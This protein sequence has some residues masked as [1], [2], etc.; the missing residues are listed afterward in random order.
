MVDLSKTHP[1]IIHWLCMFVRPISKPLCYCLSQNGIRL[2]QYSV[3]ILRTVCKYVPVCCW[4]PAWPAVFGKTCS[5]QAERT[6]WDA[7]SHNAMRS[8]WPSISSVTNEPEAILT[9]IFNLRL[10]SSFYQTA[11][12]F[13]S[14]H[15]MGLICKININMTGFHSLLRSYNSYVL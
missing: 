4:I 15:K 10:D 8:T 13:H 9:E 14:L 11:K 5:V 7:V 3:C 12:R 1:S 6:A 2:L